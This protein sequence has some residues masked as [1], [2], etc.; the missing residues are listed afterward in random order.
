MSDGRVV[1]ALGRAL[2][3]LPPDDSRLLKLRFTD[4]LAISTI[5]RQEGMDQASLYRRVA[6]LLRRLRRDLERS[7]I[8]APV[9]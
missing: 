3:T 7:G 2:R 8:A 1:A 6:A 4:G 9:H 5:A